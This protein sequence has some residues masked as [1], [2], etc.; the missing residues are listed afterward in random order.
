MVIET[1]EGVGHILF[2]LE[3]ASVAPVGHALTDGAV[4]FLAGKHGQCTQ[5]FSQQ[6]LDTV[7]LEVAHE[8][9]REV[10]GI[11][12]TFLVDL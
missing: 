5:V 7:G 6:G 8:I 9:E 12:K 10:V 11:G 3:D 2:F 1:Y 4:A